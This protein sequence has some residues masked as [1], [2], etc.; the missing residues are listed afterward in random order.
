MYFGT[1]PPASNRGVYAQDFLVFDDATEEGIDLA[2]AGILLELRRPG[3]PSP[4]LSASTGNGRIALAAEPG[5]FA[6]TIPAE[7]MRALEAVAYEAGIT[8]TQN[9]ETTQFF[10]GTL[11]VLDGI[12]S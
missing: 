12:V 1:L 7:A 10:I 5:R 6:L 3:C 9:G 11:P 8:I 4:A 2:G